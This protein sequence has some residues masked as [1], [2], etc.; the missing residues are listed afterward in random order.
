MIK[1]IKPHSNSD[2]LSTAH[3]VGARGDHHHVW[4]EAAA[5]DV[6]GLHLLFCSHRLSA[7]QRVH[8]GS[9]TTTRGKKTSKNNVD[10]NPDLSVTCVVSAVNETPPPL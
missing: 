4:T 9:E 3:H 5:E 10:L 8:Q 7:D 1:E 2:P 6:C